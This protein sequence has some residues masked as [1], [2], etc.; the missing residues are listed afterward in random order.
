[1]CNRMITTATILKWNK[2]KNRY[3][4][5]AFNDFKKH[6]CQIQRK[7]NNTDK[8]LNSQVKTDASFA[9]SNVLLILIAGV[10]INYIISYSKELQCYQ[11][12]DGTLCIAHSHDKQIYRQNA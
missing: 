11:R 5:V 4:Y 2:H 8:M 1:M 12:K 10:H 7:L 3:I 9:W 6:L